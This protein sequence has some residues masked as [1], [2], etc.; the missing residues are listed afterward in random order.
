MLDETA[1]AASGDRKSRVESR[2]EHLPSALRWQQQDPGRRVVQSERDGCEEKWQHMD[3]SPPD[4]GF[5]AKRGLEKN[6]GNDISGEEECRELPPKVPLQKPTHVK[7]NCDCGGVQESRSTDSSSK[8]AGEEEEV[9]MSLVQRLALR[10][11]EAQEKIHDVELEARASEAR[12]PLS[13]A[14]EAMRKLPLPSDSIDA[15]PA[16]IDGSNSGGKGRER[17]AKPRTGLAP[18]DQPDEGDRQEV[19]EGDSREDAS[20]DTCIVSS[21]KALI[22]APSAVFVSRDLAL[23]ASE[24]LSPSVSVGSISGQ[25]TASIRSLSSALKPI[26]AAARDPSGLI[27]PLT[28]LTPPLPLQPHAR[29][30]RSTLSS[31]AS[32]VGDS[33]RAFDH[34]MG[35]GSQET[36][37]KALVLWSPQQH[38]KTSCK[39]LQ[40][41]LQ[42]AVA[43]GHSLQLTWQV[44]PFCSSPVCGLC[45]SIREWGCERRRIFLLFL[46]LLCMI[47]MRSATPAARSAARPAEVRSPFASHFR[48]S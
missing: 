3:A 6:E 28:L 17:E 40:Q 26:R 5:R 42:Q 30:L 32:G 36:C 4:A 43:T 35:R 34:G 45:M 21:S 20:A 48:Q 33:L 46:I 27:S 47:A 13:L 44:R 10:K 14:P 12:S 39:Q 2:G 8:G 24:D 23:G 25:K 16:P 41:Q 1:E 37:V 19:G 9:Q 31:R 29:R 15:D 7:E 11:R 18:G 22:E 38:Q